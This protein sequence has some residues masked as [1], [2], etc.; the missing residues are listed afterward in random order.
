MERNRDNA[1]CCGTTAWMECSSCSKAIQ[2][3]RL[4]E[5]RQTG[6]QEL[7][8]ACPKCL[9]HLTCAQ[10]GEDIDIRVKDIYTCLAERLE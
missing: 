2:M 10:S 6:A 3:E 1:L 4:M 7:I 5:A 8:T 9:I